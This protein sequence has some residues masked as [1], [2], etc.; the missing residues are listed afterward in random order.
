[1]QGR[2][3]LKLSLEGKII[4]EFI[5]IRTAARVMKVDPK[6][7]SRR[8]DNGKALNGFKFRY[9]VQS[10]FGD[11]I[12][13]STVKLFQDNDVLKVSSEGHICRKNGVIFKGSNSDVYFRIKW[14][15]NKT[16]KFFMKHMNI[17]V[18][19]TFKNEIIGEGYQIHH[20]NGKPWD[21]NIDNLE[22]VTVPKNMQEAV[23]T[24][25]NKSCRKVRRVAHDGS[26]KDFVSLS[27]AARQTNKTCNQSISNC[28]N[29]KM[30]T[31]GLCKCGKRFTWEIPV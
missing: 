26:Y 15:N 4:E 7:I 1:M 2:T 3:V 17:L 29:G 13:K 24:G 12:W 11:L 25:K 23:A 8:C 20:K 6:T 28:L 22:K 27:E 14:R 10:D 19:E 16:K 21:N 31:S 5:S 18:W 30:K 9:K